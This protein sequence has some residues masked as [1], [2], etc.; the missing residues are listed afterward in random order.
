M[1][2]IWVSDCVGDIDAQRVVGYGIFKD[3]KNIRL[4]YPLEQFDSDVAGRSF[5]NG[6]F[7]QRMR[8]KVASLPKYF[9]FSLFC[10]YCYFVSLNFGCLLCGRFAVTFF[11]VL[12]IDRSLFPLQVCG[13]N[14]EQL[15][16][17]LRKME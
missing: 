5:H 4:S 3:G 11:L 15:H 2:S 10:F 8:E 9:C 13:W 1:I 16:R 17:C 6:R 12:I 7:I 14:K